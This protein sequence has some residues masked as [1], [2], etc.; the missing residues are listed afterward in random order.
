MKK[1]IGRIVVTFAVLA[2]LGLVGKMDY[3]DRQADD[4]RTEEIRQK[5]ILANA[6]LPP[7]DLVCLAA[8][9]PF[10]HCKSKLFPKPGQ[11]P[12]GM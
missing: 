1:L 3:Q 6:D 2:L 8:S 5:L 12:E 9:D 4:A 11:R 7:L 10:Q